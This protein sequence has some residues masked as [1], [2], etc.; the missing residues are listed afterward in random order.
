M[1]KKVLLCG[2]LAMGLAMSTSSCGSG[3]NKGQATENV[4][5]QESGLFDDIVDVCVQMSE[6]EQEMA[7]KFQEANQGKIKPDEAQQFLKQKMEEQKTLKAKLQEALQDLGEKPFPV[8]ASE[9]VGVSFSE[10]VVTANGVGTTVINIKAKPSAP[11]AG[12]SVYAYGLDSDNQIVYKTIGGVGS[13]GR[14]TAS[15]RISIFSGPSKKLIPVEQIKKYA[16]IVKLM[17]VTKE[18]YDAGFV[19]GSGAPA[20]Q[21]TTAQSA[22]KFELTSQGVDKVVIGADVKKLP[23]S[24]DGL[25]DKVVVN[26]EYNAMEDETTTNATFTLNGKDVMSA[27]AD[28]DGEIIWIG[29]TTNAV[30]V[31]I[32]DAYFQ[33]GSL[34]KDLLKAKGVKKD[35]SY[36]AVYNGI[37]FNKDVNGKISEIS[38]GSSW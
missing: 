18:E 1:K 10:G 38:V 8:S 11:V 6:N 21:Q 37:Q 22:P 2:I 4:A 19:P 7:E 31:K 14:I 27:M 5:E 26:S 23:K 20:P 36:A 29:V 24:V 12:P 33:V 32:G 9:A 30:A 35:E 25:Y 16:S 15:F 13:D 28:D 3:E 34:V 17:V